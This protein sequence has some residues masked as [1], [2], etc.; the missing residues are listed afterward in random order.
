M[1]SYYTPK[2]I[3]DIKFRLKVEIIA[4]SQKAAPSTSH[5]LLRCLDV[6]TKK[7]LVKKKSCHGLGIFFFFRTLVF[8]FMK[9]QNIEF[10]HKLGH[11]ILP[12]F[13]S[14]SLVTIFIF[15]YFYHK[16]QPPSA[17]LRYNWEEDS[18]SPSTLVF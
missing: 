4:R 9:T 3:I 8:S 7:L 14:F 16:G 10:C 15:F 6:L 5:P 18:I 13:E 17:D 1:A 2:S 12:L 11:R